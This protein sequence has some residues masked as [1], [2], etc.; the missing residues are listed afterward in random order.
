ML[1][2][3]DY[4][5]YLQCQKYL[6]LFKNRKE[7]M[8]EVSETQQA[9][10]DQGFVVEEYAQQ[11]F[12]ADQTTKFQP[13]AKT[14][15]LYAR[16]DILHFND[17]TKKWDLYEVKSSTE[18]KDEHIPDLAFQKIAFEKSG[19]PIDK[20]Y[21]IHINKE[22]VRNG[23]IDPKELLTIEDITDQVENI[24][25]ITEEQIPKALALIKN[26]NQP[27]IQIGKQCNK[28]YPCPFK[29]Y[30][31]KDV[32][33]LSIYNIQR[34]TDK[35]LTELQNLNILKIE[36]IPDDFKLNE[37]QQNQVTA[38]KTKK[39][40][41]DKEAI[42]ST[43]ETLEYPLYFLDYETYGQAI[44]L[45]NGLKP[46][47]QMPFQYSL[48]II[49][50]KGAAPEHYEY[51]H[52][53]KDN[54]IPYLLKDMRANIGDTGSVI[55]WYKGFET[56][57]NEEMAEMFPEYANFLNSINT[58][59]FDLMDIFKDQYYV[60]ADFKGSCSIKKV[61][62]VLVPEL[63]YAELEDIQ[64]GSAASLY[65]FKHIYGDSPIKD[66]ITANM[67]KY[68]ELDTMAMVEVWRRLL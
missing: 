55:V 36:D 33:E 27:Q 6:W 49:R 25:Q 46:Y 14:N 17:D 19:T 65:W 48:H 43:L 52:T 5:K 7:L 30:C 29:E 67:L 41:I 63:S 64:E 44:P 24:R 3:S 42:A 39:P 50:S 9:I 28:P 11:L 23:Q 56:S 8:P 4:L 57:R 34:L 12:T 40:I 21:L 61:L 2:K 54:P 62:P 53:G 59:I 38:T 15:D 37:K 47:Q 66:R 20:T 26:L 18:V 68:C 32:P 13:V 51:I 1:T 16:A 35:Q 31:W 10:F 60:D 58:R 45:F 22:Y